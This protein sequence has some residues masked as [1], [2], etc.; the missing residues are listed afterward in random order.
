MFISQVNLGLG[1]LAS[2]CQ[3]TMVSF[4][5]IPMTE[6]QDSVP[7]CTS[8]EGPLPRISLGRCKVPQHTY[9]ICPFQILR[10]LPESWQDEVVTILILCFIFFFVCLWGGT[11]VTLS[12]KQQRV[13]DGGRL[14]TFVG[15]SQEAGSS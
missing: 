15:D 6:I 8:P 7:A 10:K 4:K 11:H 5:L 2:R 1:T 14:V 12:S 3:T 13:V 9:A